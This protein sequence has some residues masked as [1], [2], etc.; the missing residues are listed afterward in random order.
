MW[1]GERLRLLHLLLL[2]LLLLLQLWWW[3]L[4]LRRQ[5]CQL[6]RRWLSSCSS[7]L[8]LLLLLL[9]LLSVGVGELLMVLLHPPQRYCL[10]RVSRVLTG[11]EPSAGVQ[12]ETKISEASCGCGTNGERRGGRLLLAH[13]THTHTHKHRVGS[14]GRAR[15]VGPVRLW[16]S[17]LQFVPNTKPR[18]IFGLLHSSATRIYRPIVTLA[19]LQIPLHSHAPTTQSCIPSYEHSIA[20][21]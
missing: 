2:D 7:S 14:I 12:L 20:R 17:R 15:R 6:R 10:L 4:C 9:L 11:D 18:I 21:L 19:A 8:L 13:N 16:L 3:C 5:R 1:V